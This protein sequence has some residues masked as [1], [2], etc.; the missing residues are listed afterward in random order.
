MSDIQIKLASLFLREYF[1]EIV[2]RVCAHLLK[3][4]SG[5]FRSIIAETKEKPDQ[6]LLNYSIE[7]FEFIY[8][9]RSLLQF[10]FTSQSFNKHR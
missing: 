8:L 10:S 2:D 3:N 1:G 5:I 6:V 7:V 9:H 4:G